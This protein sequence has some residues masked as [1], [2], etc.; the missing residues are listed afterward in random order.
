MKLLIKARQAGKTTQLIY[1]SEATGYPIVVP[2]C[3]MKKYTEEMA[4]KMG[5]N[6]PEPITVGELRDISRNGILDPDNVL[7]DNA[8]F[9]L[10]DALKEYLGKNV[11]CATMSLD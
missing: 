9:I 11:V 6:I 4:A 2:S 8:E 7:L 5:C 10:K 3:V 1:T